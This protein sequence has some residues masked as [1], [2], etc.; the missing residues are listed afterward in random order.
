M[1]VKKLK[2]REI[3]DENN[4]LKETSKFQEYNRLQINDK[5]RLH[6]GNAWNI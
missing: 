6:D 5:V 1:E 2:K 3:N 4:K